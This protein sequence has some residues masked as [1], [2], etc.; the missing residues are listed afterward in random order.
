MLPRLITVSAL[1]GVITCTSVQAAPAGSVVEKKQ[2]LAIAKQYAD[3]VACDTSFVSNGGPDKP[4]SISDV[5]TLSTS[6]DPDAGGSEYLVLWGGDIGCAGGSG[7]G[8][9]SL[10][11]FSNLNASHKF[12]LTEQDIFSKIAKGT[13]PINTR[14]IQSVRILSN[15]HLVVVSLDF[16]K[17]DG[18]NFPSKKY[19]YEVAPNSTGGWDVLRKKFLGKV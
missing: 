18:D 5:Y 4:T 7:T 1:L 13:Y 16:D 14:F 9:S 17:D 12:L 2:V 10:S 6:N 15:G 11:E 3:I 19:E 8:G